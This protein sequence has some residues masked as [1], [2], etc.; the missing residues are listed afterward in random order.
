MNCFNITFLINLTN[1]FITIMT[2]SKR[3]LGENGVT[4]VNLWRVEILTSQRY[5]KQVI[6]GFQI[7][8]AKKEVPAREE[9]GELCEPDGGVG[10]ALRTA[11]VSVGQGASHLDEGT[12]QTLIDPDSVSKI[13]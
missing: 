7:C 13:S 8:L 5:T 1:Q 9:R 6:A 2:S 4:K 3:S 11:V 10:P 12:R